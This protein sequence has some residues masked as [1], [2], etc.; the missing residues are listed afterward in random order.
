MHYYNDN[1]PKACAWLRELI[2][3]GL[4]PQGEVDERSITDIAPADLDGFVQCHFFA[5]IGG[6]P[7]ALRLAGWDDAR[8]VWTGS[9]PCQPFSVAGKGGGIDDERHLWPAFRWLIAQRRPAKVFG[10]QVASKDGRDWLSGVRLDLE[11]MGYAVGAADLC[12]AG[13]GSPQIRQR[14]W[15]VADGG[16]S[17][18]EGQPGDG[19][20]RNKSGRDGENVPGPVAKGSTVNWSLSVWWP[21]RDG[22]LR[23]VP[24]RRMENTGSAE[25]QPR[26]QVTG[27]SSET[28]NADGTGRLGNSASGEDDGRESRELAEAK[29]PGRCCDDAPYDA[30]ANGGI[31]DAADDNGRR[32]EC[33]TQEGAR[34]DVLSG[35]R[36]SGGGGDVPPAR[37]DGL[38]IKP[39]FL[40]LVARLPQGMD[41]SGLTCDEE[42]FPLS[43]KTEQRVGLLRGYGNAI[44]PQVAA[45][46]ITAYM[47]TVT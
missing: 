26:Q 27:S 36:S 39:F 44:V 12:A 43:S 9:C 20:E 22:K 42:L 46:F 45:A 37:H 32:G 11:A 29:G 2:A 13:L 47:E 6:W 35:C 5:G 24:A 10:E 33:G 38:E 18:L 21:C 34:T 25:L 17:G 4:I 16:K 19:R 28:A 3:A 15:W 8:P 40:G 23:R 31:S 7:L 41:G 1:D 14:L 30:G